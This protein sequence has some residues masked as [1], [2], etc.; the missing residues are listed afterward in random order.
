MNQQ[1]IDIPR[2]WLTKEIG[3]ELP[4]PTPEELQA[5]FKRLREEHQRRRMGRLA[6]RQLD[7]R[8]FSAPK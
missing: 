6:N 2:D 7:L 4:E 1:T 5:R 8:P 3:K